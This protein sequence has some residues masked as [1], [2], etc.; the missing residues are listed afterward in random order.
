MKKIVWFLCVAMLT[1]CSQSA[2]V[3]TVDSL[4]AHPDRLH[5]LERKC[6]NDDPGMTA[7]ECLIVSEARRKVFMGNGPKYTPP[8][9]TPKF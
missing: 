5:E 1:A 3:E 9:T 6:G 2:P 7:R 4:V 8:K